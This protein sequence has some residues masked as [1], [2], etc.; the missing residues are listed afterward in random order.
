[1]KSKSIVSMLS[2]SALALA[3]SGPVLAAGETGQTG[4]YQNGMAS[5]QAAADF[6]SMYKAD[7]LKDLSV[8]DSQDQQ[9][10][11][12][13]SV[14]VDDQGEVHVVVRDQQDMNYLVPWDRVTIDDQQQIASIDVSQDQ[15]SM[16][17]S[18][19]E[20]LPPTALDGANGAMPGL[21]G[22]PRDT[23]PGATDPD[24]P[25]PGGF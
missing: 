18:A 9:I 22:E 15:L 20:E 7:N 2:A 23:S 8:N 4:Q 11:S 19:F 6:S 5:P 25:S 24:Q 16:E 10:G 1:M 17:F 3:M 13:D 21:N 14:L 12:I